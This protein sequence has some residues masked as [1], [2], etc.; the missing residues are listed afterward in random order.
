[1]SND[2]FLTFFFKNRTDSNTYLITN[3]LP[4]IFLIN[5]YLWKEKEFNIKMSWWSGG[6]WNLNQ[7]SDVIDNVAFYPIFWLVLE[8]LKYCT[9]PTDILK[10]LKVFVFDLSDLILNTLKI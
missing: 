6:V 1:M 3:V 9:V 8:I 7:F 2:F 5:L 4:D 10:I